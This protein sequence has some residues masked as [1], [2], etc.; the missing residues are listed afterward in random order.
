MYIFIS[1]IYII[2][3]IH[4]SVL[5]TYN[6]LL[7]PGS[8]LFVTKVLFE[9][10]GIYTCV[11]TYRHVIKVRW[12]SKPIVLLILFPAKKSLV[13]VHTKVRL[14]TTLREEGLH[15]ILSITL[16]RIE[17]LDILDILLIVSTLFISLFFTSFINIISVKFLI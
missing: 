8:L 16:N 1:I 2:N 11:V 17:D 7:L 13:F 15:F 9:P 4:C 6:T 14:Q 10:W 5:H 3:S 12:L